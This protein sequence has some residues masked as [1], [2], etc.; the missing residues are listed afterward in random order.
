MNKLQKISKYFDEHIDE[1]KKSF[2]DLAQ[3]EQKKKYEIKKEQVDRLNNLQNQ[4]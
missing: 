2:K 1:I 3:Q 4:L